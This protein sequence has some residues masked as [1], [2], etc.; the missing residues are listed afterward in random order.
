[1]VPAIDPRSPASPVGPLSKGAVNRFDLR[2]KPG[3]SFAD[4]PM[5]CLPRTQKKARMAA[6]P[7]LQLPSRRP[8]GVVC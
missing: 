4:K 7:I 1:M 2:I 3:A 8:R 6:G 5:S